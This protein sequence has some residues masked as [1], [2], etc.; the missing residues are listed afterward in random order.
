MLWR[1][2]PQWHHA[3]RAL[4]DKYLAR[5]APSLAVNLFFSPCVLGSLL[6][7]SLVLCTAIVLIPAALET[8]CVKSLLWP[9]RL[10]R[11]HH[12]STRTNGILRRSRM[13]GMFRKLI[14]VSL[15]ALV[16]ADEQINIIWKEK[17]Q[18]KRS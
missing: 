15:V 11:R 7:S 4:E 9:L 17:A 3:V 14:V 10:A 12:L 18:R 1:H 6:R 8:R 5:L 2:E 13:D 16:C